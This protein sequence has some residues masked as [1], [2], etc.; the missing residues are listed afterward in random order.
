MEDG[1]IF[2]EVWGTGLLVCSKREVYVG[3]VKEGRGRGTAPGRKGMGGGGSK[4]DLA[5]ER[6]GRLLA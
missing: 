3:A 4:G 1:L 6:R 2:T 5:F